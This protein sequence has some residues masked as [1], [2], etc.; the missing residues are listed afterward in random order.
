MFHGAN[1]L[2]E[3]KS[4][5]LR[6]GYGTDYS[7][8]GHPRSTSFCVMHIVYPSVQTPGWGPPPKEHETNKGYL[9]VIKK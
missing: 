7:Q 1:I 5:V 6:V 4:S 3:T 2:L 8:P 9:P